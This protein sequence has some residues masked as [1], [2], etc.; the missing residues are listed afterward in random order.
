[1]SVNPLSKHIRT[2]KVCRNCEQGFMARKL[3][4]FC[5]ISCFR[6]HLGQGKIRRNRKTK[7]WP[8]LHCS[9][10]YKRTSPRH[11]YCSMQCSTAAKTEG[12]IVSC[13]VCFKHFR[14]LNKSMRINNKHYCSRACFN[15]QGLANASVK[16]HKSSK[17][18]KKLLDSAVCECGESRRF[19]LDVH[20]KD[21]DR[22]NNHPD[23]LEVVCAT[24]HRKRH[25]R[26]N[27]DGVLVYDVRVL[28]DPEI[29][30]TL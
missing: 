20:H 23:N 6:K 9:K 5:S 12:S 19:A 30:K 22:L 11:K 18:W 21:S 14:T 4:V 3:Q 29:F 27:K 16:L 15:N 8:C 24:C 10:E 25:L 28:T 26:L 1:M 7:L 17:Y 2:H 13:H